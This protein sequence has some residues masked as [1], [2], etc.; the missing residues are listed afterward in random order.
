MVPA[1]RIPALEPP[2]DPEVAR[3]LERMMGG[4]GLEPPL[5]LSSRRAQSPHTGQVPEHWVVPSE[6]RNDRSH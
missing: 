6:L 3:S 5:A 1:P 4:L 2:Y